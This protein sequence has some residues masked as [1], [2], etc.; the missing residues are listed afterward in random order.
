MDGNES[1]GSVYGDRQGFARRAR[2][3]MLEEK[4]H[5]YAMV[6]SGVSGF[7]IL[8]CAPPILLFDASNWLVPTLFTVACALLALAVIGLWRPGP[9]PVRLIIPGALTAVLGVCLLQQIAVAGIAVIAGNVISVALAILLVRIDGE[10][11]ALSE[12]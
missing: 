12:T 3:R 5:K 2:V 10:R 8:S 6:I 4:A 7:T 9:T 1:V 11:A